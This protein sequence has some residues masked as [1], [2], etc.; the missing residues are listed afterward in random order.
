MGQV[1]FIVL[2]GMMYSNGCAVTHFLE[3]TL[4]MTSQP[5]TLGFYAA[6]NCSALARSAVAAFFFRT[7]RSGRNLWCS[8]AGA[9]TR[10]CHSKQVRVESPFPNVSERYTPAVAYFLIFG[11]NASK[12]G[13]KFGS[14][15]H[16]ISPSVLESPE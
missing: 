15:R 16:F 6:N 8:H 5:H 3:H 13:G 2:S 9:P 10:C 12:S 1:R 14:S 4:I 11:K 7:M